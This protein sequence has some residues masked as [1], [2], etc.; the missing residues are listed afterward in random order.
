MDVLKTAVPVAVGLA[1]AAYM[2]LKLA[3]KTGTSDFS[4]DSTIPT[5]AIRE[6]DLSHDA[7]Y[8][9]D[10]DKFLQ[11]CEERYG[12]VFNLYALGQKLT[13]VSGPDLVKDVF[14]TDALNF[15][16]AMDQL[17]GLHAF[18][19]SIRKSNKDAENRT[20]HELIKDAIASKMTEFTPR[21]V[22]SAERVITRTLSVSDEIIV[23]NLGNVIQEVIATA[24]ANLFMGPELEMDPKV[25]HTFIMCTYDFGLMISG[26]DHKSFWHSITNKFKY[27]V[28]SPLQRHV[29]V[30]VDATTP[31]LL[32]RREQEA[33]ALEKGKDYSAS[34]N[35]LQ[36][37][38][39]KSSKYGYIDLEDICG[40]ILILVLASVHSTAIMT[41]QAL[42]YMAAYPE[43]MEPLY[44]EIQEV[45]NQQ[46]EERE[47]QRRTKLASGEMRSSPSTFANT[48]LDPMN[49][50]VLTE[51]AVRRLEK[52]DSFV[53]ESMRYDVKRLFGA[54]LARRDAVLS[55]GMKITKGSRVIVNATSVHFSEELQGT[56]PFGFQPWRFVGKGKGAAK[57]AVDNL[58][59]GMGR[60]VCP[61]RF[62]AVHEIKIVCALLVSRFSRLEIM[63]KEKT[64][65]ML[66]DRLGYVTPPSP[67]MMTRRGRP[68]SSTPKPAVI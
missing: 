51:K 49:D 40:H 4:Q 9:E 35:I 48:D 21:I 5:A 54:H 3:T 17:T 8:N 50:R 23:D 68:L 62:L 19:A 38:L 41:T 33:E 15:S 60:H 12:P 18:M 34:E 1:S 6:G 37:M 53:R 32:K 16:D 46:T 7:E 22:K 66:L 24:M 28:R 61:G 55:N 10:P 27:N 67:I 29:Q 14:M 42:Y 52:M 43:Y 36:T 2:G 47:E 11:R 31:V 45:L 65:D 39:D 57:A 20:P 63:E 64:M 56:E 26:S 30:L 59:F 13:C 58:P 25:I 44:D